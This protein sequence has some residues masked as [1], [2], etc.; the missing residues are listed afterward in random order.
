MVRVAIVRHVV[1]RDHVER[2]VGA[3]PAFL[4]RRAHVERDRPAVGIE[5]RLQACHAHRAIRRADE[6][7]FAR[8]EQMDRDA[9]VRVRDHDRLLGL[10]AVAVAAEAA[11][12]MA[13]VQMDVLL[14]DAGDLRGA[15]ARFLGALI[16]DPDVHAIA[17]DEH[18]GVAGLHA[19]AAADTAS[20]TWPRR[21][22]RRARRPRRH[23]PD[24]RA[25]CRADR[26]PPAATA[27]MFAVLNAA[28]SGGIFHSIG[29]R[30][31]AVLA[32]YQVSAMTA[33]PP[34]KTRPRVSAGIRNRELHGGAHA[35]H[36]ANRFEVV[37]L[38]VAAIDG[39]RLHGR[40]FHAGH[41]DV[42]PVHRLAGHLERHV[43]ILLLGAHQRPLVRRLDGDR[44]RMRMRRLR[45]R[46]RRSGRRSS[47]GRST[48]A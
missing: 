16:A 13:Q 37:A 45:R 34:L 47:C 20:S 8:P 17:G 26:A 28:C 10:G 7:L 44:L 24:R 18:R 48:R 43:E 38:D 19:R 1:A 14:G 42:D 41:A 6:I 35:R 2:G 40:P 5:T 23:R 27:C 36:L 30:S 29:I 25:R 4:H 12:Q 46:D 32:W 39:T 15:E 21:S 11:A 9:A 3:E 33:T 22:W 31:S